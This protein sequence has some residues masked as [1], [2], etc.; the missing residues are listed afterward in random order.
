M[1]SRNIQVQCSLLTLAVA[2]EAAVSVVTDTD[3]E[4]GESL[5]SDPVES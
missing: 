5:I 2:T 4:L 1:D 3:N